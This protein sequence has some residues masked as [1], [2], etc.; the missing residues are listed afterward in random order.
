MAADKNGF[1]LFISNSPY[2]FIEHFS[3]SFHDKQNDGNNLLG[4]EQIIVVQNDNIASWLKIALAE[5]YGIAMQFKFKFPEE[6]IRQVLSHF[7]DAAKLLYLDEMRML[8]EVALAKLPPHHPISQSI[9]NSSSTKKARDKRR[10]EMAKKLSSLFHHYNHNVLDLPQAWSQGQ[11]LSKTPS[12]LVLENWQRQLWGS[13]FLGEQG[14]SCLWQM[15]Q[16][17]LPLQPS[18]PLPRLSILGTAFLSAV[19]INL[20]H[21]FSNFTPVKQYMLSPLHLPKPKELDMVVQ[22]WGKLLFDTHGFLCSKPRVQVKTEYI[23]HPQTDILNVIKELITAANSLPQLELN[24]IDFSTFE[25]IGCPGRRRE[26][27]VLKNKIVHLLEKDSQ[28]KL[29]EIGV[30]A[31]DINDYRFF[32][33][34]IF[35]KSEEHPSI[36][37]NIVDLNYDSNNPLLNGYHHIL[38]LAHSSF[39]LDDI[40]RLLGNPAVKTKLALLDDQVERFMALARNLNI[41]WG[42][43]EHH[44]RQLK[45]G[46]G[47]SNTWHQGLNRVILG[48]YYQSDLQSPRAEAHAVLNREAEETAFKIFSFLND[49]YLD[50]RIL[51]DLSQTMAYWVDFSKGLIEQYLISSP[52]ELFHQ[53]EKRISQT[54]AQLLELAHRAEDPVINFQSFKL[55]WEEQISKKSSARGAYLTGG[56]TFS[57]LKPM[58]A[59]PFKHIFL[60][61]LNE[62]DFPKEAVPSEMDLTPQIMIGAGTGLNYDGSDVDKFSFLET[63]CSA[64][65]SLHILYHHKDLLNHN[66]LHPSGVVSQIVGLL[67]QRLSQ[68]AKVLWE[69]LSQAHPLH[70]FDPSYFSSPQLENYSSQDYR[71]ALTLLQQEPST[72][73]SQS[74]LSPEIDSIDISDLFRLF[75]QPASLFLQKGIGANMY[76]HQRK[77]HE[78]EKTDLPYFDWLEFLQAAPYSGQSYDDFVKTLTGKGSLSGTHFDRWPR[79]KA[80]RLTEECVAAFEE[81]GVMGKSKLEYTLLPPAPAA[82]DPRLFRPLPSIYVGGSPIVIRG[83]MSFCY[84][85]NLLFG[86]ARPTEENKPYCYLRHYLEALV[87]AFSRGQDQYG[88]RESKESKNQKEPAE[89]YKLVAFNPYWKRRKAT[90]TQVSLSPLRAQSLLTEWIELYCLHLKNPLPLYL[91]PLWEFII[92][93]GGPDPEEIASVVDN[94]FE[95]K[96]RQEKSRYYQLFAPF[97]ATELPWDKIKSLFEIFV[98]S[99]RIDF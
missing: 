14:F 27:E 18:S 75:D 45:K 90:A 81:L 47:R 68:P 51:E 15:Y 29:H 95:R 2:K 28:L 46:E 62:K 43:D 3:Y 25:V 70:A 10:F 49:L 13:L 80:R 56:I 4:E 26:I 92:K 86:G 50:T 55:H 99:Q 67:S 66:T 8:L 32:I 23:K 19:Q 78:R 40:E 33:E 65:E 61:G 74:P 36:P 31:L 79:E 57:S 41:V 9:Q 77:S 94:Y 64:Q 72:K 93:G 89:V 69:R 1:R 59:I 12:G 17:V 91:A 38:E 44:R 34:S 16:K 39:H 6:A 54:F 5:R 96:D 63:L 21:H 83:E 60:L 30:M 85:D 82:L 71:A 48:H 35:S 58:R 7:L 42:M 22:D 52:G 37:H 20:F 76:E 24:D 53:H 88:N 11:I 98:T 87:L 84:Q 73:P 97:E